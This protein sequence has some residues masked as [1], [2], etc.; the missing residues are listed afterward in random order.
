M[1]DARGSQFLCLVPLMSQINIHLFFSGN[2]DTY[3]MVLEKTVI[4]IMMVSSLRR[5]TFKG[6]VYTICNKLPWPAI[7]ISL[8]L[9]RLL[10]LFISIGGQQHRLRRISLSFHNLLCSLYI[11]ERDIQSQPRIHLYLCC[12]PKVWETIYKILENSGYTT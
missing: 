2:R 3:S 9:T 1:R 6:R 7:L 12:Q 10:M 8:C 11:A 5:M 4:M